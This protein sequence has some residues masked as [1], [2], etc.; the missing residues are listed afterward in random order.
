MNYEEYTHV[1]G[2]ADADSD[3]V[4]ILRETFE[5]R[6]TGTAGF[7]VLQ[8]VCF[9]MWCMLFSCMFFALLVFLCF[10][11]GFSSPWR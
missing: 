3:I 4:G 8:Y 10:R 11:C 5:G 6:L 1:A 9:A 7:A 2:I